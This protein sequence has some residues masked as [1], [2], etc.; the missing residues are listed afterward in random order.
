MSSKNQLKEYAKQVKECI[1]IQDYREAM[2]VLKKAIKIDPNNFSMVLYCGF[3]LDKLYSSN[4]EEQ[5]FQEA[6]KAYE[7]AIEL[8]KT[9]EQPLLGL[10][11][12]YEKKK[13]DSNVK[14]KLYNIYEKLNVLLKGKDEEKWYNT[15]IK[16]YKLIK[17]DI[18]TLNKVELD[19]QIIKFE[20]IVKTLFDLID[21]KFKGTTKEI[22]LLKY[23]YMLD[24]LFIEE[25]KD[26]ENVEDLLNQK[27][28]EHLIEIKEREKKKLLKTKK[29]LSDREVENLLPSDKE[30]LSNEKREELKKGWKEEVKQNYFLNNLESKTDI[31]LNNIVKFCKTND[32]FCDL[33]IFDNIIDRT[34]SRLKLINDKN[35]EEK[36]RIKLIETCKDGIEMHR[37]YYKAFEILF[38][39]NEEDNVKVIDE[40]L[41][42]EIT[43]RLLY[44]FPFYG[45]TYI[46]L[47]ELCKKK[48][49]TSDKLE[50]EL[51]ILLQR[52]I[53]SN[54]NLILGWKL[55]CELYIEKNQFKN[56][57]EIARKGLLI[58]ENRENTT[59]SSLKKQK[60]ELTIL[61]GTTL[62][63]S[64]HVDEAEQ[65]FNLILTEMDVKNLAALKGLAE[66]EFSKGNLMKSR[67]Y[68]TKVIQLDPKDDLTLCQTG[69]FSYLDK[70]FENA[71]KYIKLAIDVNPNNYLYYYRLALVYWNWNSSHRSNTEYCFS[72]FLK[73]AKLNP[74]F[75]SNY[76]YLGHYYKDIER[77][78]ERCIKCYRKAVSLNALEEE[79]GLNLGDIYIRKGQLTLAAS[80]FR[81]ATSKNSRAGWAWSKLGFYEQSLNKLDES[82][83]C[84]QH[85]IRVKPNDSLCWEGLGESYK[86]EGKYLAALK[87]FSKAIE[88][89]SS[90]V[91]S[92]VQS[93]FITYQL[94]EFDNSRGMY[95]KVIS[96]D[97]NYIVPYE[98]IAE[99]LFKFATN[100]FNDG[101]FSK[102]AHQLIRAQCALIYGMKRGYEDKLRSLW[103]SLGDIQ[104]Y[105]FFYPEKSVQEASVTYLDTFKDDLNLYLT[106]FKSNHTSRLH[107]L[108][109][110]ENSYSKLI[111]FDENDSDSWY[112]LG[113]CQTYQFF[114]YSEQGLDTTLMEEVREKAISNIKKAI[115]LNPNRTDFWNSLGII[116]SNPV[117]KQHCFIRAIQLKNKNYK[118]WN[119]LGTLYLQNGDFKLARKAFLK[120]QTLRPDNSLSWVG[121]ALVNETVANRAGV[122]RAKE[123]FKHSSTLEYTSAGVLGLA[124]TSLLSK[125]SLYTV[126]SIMKYFQFNSSD[127]SAYNIL[128]VALELQQQYEKSL[129]AFEKAENLLAQQK[130]KNSK[131]QEIKL[132]LSNDTSSIVFQEDDLFSVDNMLY[133]VRVNK[134]RVL[135]KLSKY[136]EANSVYEL[137]KQ[138][139]GD[140]MGI[141]FGSA[142]SN[143]YSTDSNISIKS[144]QTALENS[145]KKLQEG[146]EQEGRIIEIY[147]LFAKVFYKQK[148]YKKAKEYLERCIK[149]YPKSI[150]TYH[151]YA[152]L[153]ILT[154]PNKPQAALSIVKQIYQNIDP[155]DIETI[156][157]E[158]M[159]HACIGNFEK[160]RNSIC[161][162][163]H[164][165]PYNAKL[166]DALANVTI[167]HQFVS[168]TVEQRKKPKTK[169]KAKN[170]LD[171]APIPSSNPGTLSQLTIQILESSI[172]KFALEVFGN[173]K[174]DIVNRLFNIASLYYSMGSAPSYHDAKVTIRHALSMTQKAIILDPSNIKLRRLLAACSHTLS[175]LEQ[176][177]SYH[178]IAASL[179][180]SYLEINGTPL[181]NQVL[182][183]EEDV[184][185]INIHVALCEQYI[186]LKEYTKCMTHVKQVMEKYKE[187]PAIESTLHSVLAKCVLAKGESME[188]VLKLFT[189]ALKKDPNNTY[190]WFTLG[191]IFINM[192]KF[193]MAEYCLIVCSK[194]S[195]GKLHQSL[196]KQFIANVKLA[197][198][199]L[200]LAVNSNS[201]EVIDLAT[202]G[203]EYAKKAMSINNESAPLYLIY[204]KLCFLLQNLDEATMYYQHA[205]R[206]DP[207][208]PLTALSLYRIYYIQEN[209]EKAEEIIWAEKANSPDQPL[210]YYTLSVYALESGIPEPA[211]KMI[212]KAIR[213]DPSNEEYWNYLTVIKQSIGK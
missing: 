63:K 193:K 85:A 67:E 212:Q 192:K 113:V 101:L 207:R 114:I 190:S 4:L 59:R 81:E 151:T 91:F 211:L 180:L 156:K 179:L 8:D 46:K 158:S 94:G 13:K 103:K 45:L 11:E 30:L 160:A 90:L 109:D 206:L 36:L 181:E 102:S 76:T 21:V 53:D 175:L 177:D 115:S 107:Y 149:E 19:K 48:Q 134:A 117:V 15:L 120:A 119:N 195:S 173:N 20:Q 98:G 122:F 62:H 131:Q 60:L 112:D 25:Y 77:D 64:G 49:V 110:A 86:R 12:L 106:N 210:I 34:N 198:V 135:C 74:T 37:N 171:D 145:K 24:Q 108:K 92:M 50:E 75:S 95:E 132:G 128:G 164:L 96:V 140:D 187:K 70:D 163:L 184:S 105:F 78:E 155:S 18:K 201:N 130:D 27:I 148:D 104:T 88:L 9:S 111:S 54:P 137:C 152:S 178:K 55:L 79:A 99:V 209:W 153:L 26:S 38:L 199:Y 196:D 71:V 197:Y 143:C 124:Y 40:K 118:A 44:L 125:D 52:G 176:K 165:F 126:Q 150:E 170:E 41:E 33:N 200:M 56:S 133:L 65:I 168:E 182:K 80:L 14:K 32:I 23:E 194:L 87:A 68:Y 6:E 89:N 186:F 73:S 185:V 69:W 159:I 42:S 57:S 147:N 66:I 202:K 146:E 82:I 22:S 189:L 144:L 31:M 1:A 166:W 28:Q 127:Y 29:K 161:K 10:I 121:L 16:Y 2:K 154:E 93:A 129:E 191:D 5:Y 72:N 169:K 208:Q 39:L 43:K 203:F 174:E 183:F 100:L 83:L 84:F 138:L 188:K 116:S 58:I 123:D 157:L 172:S 3:C 51:I 47:F 136:A 7:K 141:V 35:L 17:E 97:E 142:V 162:A 204:G 205:L 167:S 213:L 61:R 139:S